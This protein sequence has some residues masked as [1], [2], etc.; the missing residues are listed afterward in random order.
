[1]SRA[2]TLAA[3]GLLDYEIT[4]PAFGLARGRRG[5][6]PKITEKEAVKAITDYQ[7]LALDLHPTAVL[8]RRVRA[9]SN[10]PSVHEAHYVALAESLAV[11]LITSD[12]RIERSGAARCAIETFDAPG[13]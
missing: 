10:N 13:T 1:M 12:A 3:P 6:K 5:S 4:S 11:P 9:L 2:D 8:W 7:A